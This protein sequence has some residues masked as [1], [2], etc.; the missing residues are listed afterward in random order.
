M[1]VVDPD[2][3]PSNFFNQNKNMKRTKPPTNKQSF[4]KSIININVNIDDDGNIICPLIK[5][6]FIKQTHL[7]HNQINIVRRRR[8]T[9]AHVLK[10]KNTK[11]EKINFIELFPKEWQNN[12]AF[13][14]TIN[15]FIIHRKEKKKTITPLSAKRLATKLNKHSLPIVISAI[16]RSIDSG[17]TGV[18]PESE[19]NNTKYKPSYKEWEGRRYYLCPDGEYRNKFGSLF[20]E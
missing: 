12:E 14:K 16:N 9:C 11:K 4:S 7:F 2:A 5:L 17:W 13:Q 18:F 19:S 3:K 1:G 6:N 8:R 10:E 20:I 15:D